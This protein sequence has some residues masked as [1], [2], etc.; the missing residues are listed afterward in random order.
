MRTQP[1]RWL[2]DV[3]DAYSR[4]VA[5]GGS[6]STLYVIGRSDP[7]PAPDTSGRGGGRAPGTSFSSESVRN[8]H[9]RAI[10]CDDA[11]AVVRWSVARI[12]TV[13]FNFFF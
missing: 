10:K 9:G 5:F 6:A 11:A 13:Q 12:R 1:V 8:F 4:H 7:A 2:G 3:S